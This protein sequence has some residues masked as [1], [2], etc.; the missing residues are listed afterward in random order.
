MQNLRKKMQKSYCWE[1]ASPY[2][3]TVPSVREQNQTKLNVWFSFRRE[4]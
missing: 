1:K 4:G 2:V 3:S